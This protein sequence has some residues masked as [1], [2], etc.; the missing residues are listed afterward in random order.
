MNEISQV[1][2]I[3]GLVVVSILFLI[4]IIRWILKKLR[5]PDFD[6]LSREDLQK[7]W[8]EIE[9]LVSQNSEMSFKLAV[10]EADKLLDHALKS[11][12]FG[13]T[14]LGERLKLACYRFPRLR[15]VWPAHLLRNK[16]VHEAS[17]HLSRGAARNAIGEFKGALKELSVL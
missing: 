16:L 14:T 5:Q 13:G 17:F 7:K 9:S 8:R 4:F 3:L 11:L 10:M 6:G 12:G 2:I 15:R 1:W